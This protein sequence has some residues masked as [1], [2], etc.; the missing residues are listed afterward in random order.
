[1]ASRLRAL[2][3]PRELRSVPSRSSAMRRMGIGK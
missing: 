3:S 1:M 2:N